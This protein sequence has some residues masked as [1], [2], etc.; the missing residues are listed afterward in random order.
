EPDKPI[1]CVEIGGGLLLPARAECLAACRCREEQ[2]LEAHVA[3]RCRLHIQPPE[4]RRA[5]VDDVGS[6]VVGHFRD[7]YPFVVVFRV[8]EIP[9]A[10]I[11][12]RAATVHPGKDALEAAEAGTAEP[13]TRDESL[14]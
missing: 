3:A 10:A 14:D 12:T 6:V 13:R 8:G 4:N 9:D 1:V 2:A 7:W 5:L 11:E